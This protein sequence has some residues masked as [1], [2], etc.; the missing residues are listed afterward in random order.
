[1]L[2]HLYLGL[3][4]PLTKS[5]R[6][7]QESPSFCVGTD[8]QPTHLP[9]IIICII[10]VMDSRDAAGGNILMMRRDEILLGSASHECNPIYRYQRIWTLTDGTAA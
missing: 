6:P 7:N 8:L 5:F 9:G 2:V 4:R 1:M 10:D 3:F